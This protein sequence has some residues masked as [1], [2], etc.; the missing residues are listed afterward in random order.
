MVMYIAVT[1]KRNSRL[2]RINGL[3]ENCSHVIDSL[4]CLYVSMSA[5]KT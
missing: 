1:L 4:L 5:R 2:F 3:G